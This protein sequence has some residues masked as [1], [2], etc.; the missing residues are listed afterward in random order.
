MPR[1]KSVALTL[2]HNFVTMMPR[3][4]VEFGIGREVFEENAAFHFRLHNPAVDLITEIRMRR[5]NAC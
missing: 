3:M 1:N 2:K 4:N 5:E